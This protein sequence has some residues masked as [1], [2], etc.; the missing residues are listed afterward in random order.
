MASILKAAP[1]LAKWQTWAIIAVVVFLLIIAKKQGWFLSPGERGAVVDI[2]DDTGN[3]I[4]DAEAH[5][6]AKAFHDLLEGYDFSGDAFL[7]GIYAIN[8]LSNENIV[9]VANV[10]LQMYPGQTMRGDLEAEYCF[11]PSSAE[12]RTVLLQRFNSLPI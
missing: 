11:W 3:Q 1:W 6:K 9:K 5:N 8:S 12:A 4:S 7:K 2:P 10:Y